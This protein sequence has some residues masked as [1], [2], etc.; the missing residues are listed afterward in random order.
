MKHKIIKISIF[1]LLLVI[2]L[3]NNVFAISSSDGYQIESYNIDMNVN[4]DNTFDITETIEVNFTGYGKHGIFRKIPLRNTVERVDGTKSNNRAKITNISVN[5]EFKT[6]NDSGYKVIKIG[7][8]SKTVSGRKTYTIKYTYNIG[9]DPLENADELYFN[10]I[11][12]EWDTSINNVNFTINMPKSFDKTKLGFSTGY[13]YSIN[14]SKVTYNVVG[15]TI[16]G[17]VNDQLYSGQGVTVRLTLPEGYFVGA[18][19]NFDYTM[20]LKIAISI[21]C[22]IIAYSIWNKYGRDEIVV[23]TVE[24]YPPDGLN[25]ADVA[26]IYNGQS[27]QKDV[28]SLLIY[29]ANKGYLK[30]EEY[31]QTTL[32]IFKSNN[33]KIIKVK[34]YDG[35]NENEREFFNGLFKS[36][37][38]KDEVVIEELKQLKR[39]ISINDLYESKT[40]VTRSDLYDRFYVTLNKIKN[41]INR[42]ENKEKIFEKKSLGKRGIILIMIAIIFMLMGGLSIIK[43]GNVG[44]IV[45]IGFFLIG[46]LVLLCNNSNVGTV[47]LNSVVFVIAG[48]LGM[49]VSVAGAFSIS[50]WIEFLIHGVCMVLLIIFLAIIKKRTKYGTE[51][52]GRIQ[53]FKNFLEMAEKPKLEQLV[54]EDPEYFYNILPYTYALG[55]SSKWMK[56]FEDIALEAPHWYY[57][58][59]SFSTRSFNSFMN[60]TYSSI[61]NAMSYDS[62]SSGGSGGGS[63]GGGSGGGGGGSW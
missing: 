55:V 16:K 21:I 2:L 10:L 26:F 30:I 17:S 5:D 22:V 52:L 11:G 13:R 63:S 34:E 33:F 53:G 44:S 41:N 43:I 36:T 47:I 45:L 27:E 14:S 6:S 38:L 7:N 12:T 62:S 32:K 49:G 3:T 59:T 35:D 40:E 48:F 56:K 9:K 31:Q 25:S 4:E 24:F 61:S 37:E 1:I 46:P 57:G 39:K 28:I 15:N 51:M 18:S 54:M 50:F 42:K 19:S 60:S 23:D 8:A 20:L 29:L 58:Y